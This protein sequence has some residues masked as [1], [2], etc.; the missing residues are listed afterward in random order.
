MLAVPYYEQISETSCGA[1]ALEMVV[2][3]YRPSKLSKFSQRKVFAKLKETDPHSKEAHRI[4]TVD[5]VSAATS[6][7]LSANWGRVSPDV[8]TMGAQIDSFLGQGIPLIACQ[9]F[10]DELYFLG[11]FRVV[12]GLQDGNVIFHDPSPIFGK[13]QRWPLDKFSDYWKP[14]GANV[15]GGVAVWIAEQMLT[16]PGL[17]P[18]QSAL[19]SP[20]SW[21]PPPDPVPAPATP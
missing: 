8:P 2:R 5:L 1:A 6:R 11:H 15:T 18:Q 13:K 10:T 21:A 7:G 19:W 9:R 20:H 12:I 17:L 14:T 16:Q 4:K 3:F